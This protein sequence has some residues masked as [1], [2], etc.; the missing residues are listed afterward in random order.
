MR[1]LLLTAVLV[2]LT[3]QCA[4]AHDNKK[5]I[6]AFDRM[7]FK[8]FKCLVHPSGMATTFEIKGHGHYPNGA[9]LRVGIR[10]VTGETTTEYPYGKPGGRQQYVLWRTVFV[11]DWD[12]NLTVQIKDFRLPPGEYVVAAF[13]LLASQSP[14]VRSTFKR[15]YVPLADGKKPCKGCRR[16]FGLVK[17][18]LVDPSLK[19]VPPFKTL[20]GKTWQRQKAQVQSEVLAMYRDWIQQIR[21]AREALAAVRG[22]VLHI[23]PLAEA[24]IAQVIAAQDDQEQREQTEA[25]E[26]LKLAREG[27]LKARSLIKN[28]RRKHAVPASPYRYFRLLAIGDGMIASEN[29]TDPNPRVQGFTPWRFNY[30]KPRLFLV[31]KEMARYKRLNKIIQHRATYYHIK[32]AAEEVLKMVTALDLMIDGAGDLTGK[33]GALEKLLAAPKGKD[34]KDLALKVAA[35]FKKRYRNP[36]TDARRADSRFSNYLRKVQKATKSPVDFPVST[37]PLPEAISKPPKLTPAQRAKIQ[38]ANFGDLDDEMRKDGN[39]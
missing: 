12:W 26:T 11:N 37:W 2:C 28:V 25:I 7:D 22:S 15:E 6:N 4:A 36:R 16:H 3:A 23:S 5:R 34:K 31:L 8:S 20:P 24:Q 38:K 17:A 27:L 39:K 35:E 19:L 10:Y 33:G 14:K 29:P 32:S 18:V 21:D 30:V 1:R 9:M 13:F